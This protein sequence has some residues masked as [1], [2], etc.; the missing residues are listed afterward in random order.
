MRLSWQPSS[1]GGDPQ[2]AAVLISLAPGSLTSAE[3]DS[4]ALP[5]FPHL[6]QVSWG[7]GRVHSNC[8]PYFRDACLFCLMSMCLKLSYILSVFFLFFFFP[9]LSA[10]R[11]QVVPVPP[12]WLRG[13]PCGFCKCCMQWGL[14]WL[15][16]GWTSFWIETVDMSSQGSKGVQQAGKAA[17]VG[18]GGNLQIA[19]R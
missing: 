17:M 5:P 6:L 4:R 1:R 9:V 8:R 12:C 10:E 19:G 15:A 3:K 11:I 13:F 16:G 7:N 2:T 18:R 14:A